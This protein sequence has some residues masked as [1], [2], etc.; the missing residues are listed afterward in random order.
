MWQWKTG[1]TEIKSGNSMSVW[2]PMGK[3]SECLVVH[4][5][6]SWISNKTEITGNPLQV[7]RWKA[8]HRD[9]LQPPSGWTVKKWDTNMRFKIMEQHRFN[10]S[11]GNLYGF[12]VR[13]CL[14]L[15]SILFL[16]SVYELCS[17]KCSKCR[18]LFVT[19]AWCKILHNRFSDP[20]ALYL[21]L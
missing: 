11:Y 13:P 15:V 16:L 6:T 4:Q 2:N 21:G 3:T 12:Q 18:I 17:V 8:Q 5:C 9:S 19:H 1:Q 7:L 20:S 10:L 14:C